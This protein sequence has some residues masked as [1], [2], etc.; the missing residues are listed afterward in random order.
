MGLLRILLAIAVLCGHS[1]RFANL[2]WIGS[3]TA[4]EVFFVISGFYMQLV[5]TSKYTREKL[6]EH[7]ARKFFTARYL[8]LFPTYIAGAALAVAVAYL[9]QRRGR[10]IEP[11]STWASLEYLPHAPR[12]IALL[13]FLGMTDLTMLFQ[14]ATM[15]L[16]VNHGLARFAWDFHVTDIPLWTGLPVPQA[17]SLGIELS[18]YLLAPL[19]LARTNKQIATIAFVALTAKVLFLVATNYRDPWTYR[20]FPFEL[21]WF[22]L[23][24][25]AYRKRSTLARAFGFLDRRYWKIAAYVAIVLFVTCA[26]QH[27]IAS[28]LYPG[29]FTLLIPFIFNATAQDATDRYIGDLSYPF[30]IFHFLALNVTHFV[31]KNVTAV[32]RSEQL[33]ILAALILTLTMAIVAERLES[34]W[35]EP[36][37]RTLA[38]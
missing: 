28:F 36:F 1:A 7:W 21:G 38:T 19:L 25:L 14:D 13:A 2:R 32:A 15:F 10:P 29:I 24:A 26:T 33:L 22:L 27:A 6:G 17:W 4:V 9:S 23:G 31:L 12:N 16:A 8:R 3:D 30:Y 11:V 5:L 18:F 35:I 34:T 20:F 37:R